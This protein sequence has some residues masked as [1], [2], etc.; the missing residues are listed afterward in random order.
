MKIAVTERKS[1]HQT[2]TLGSGHD[3]MP[4]EPE[5]SHSFIAIVQTYKQTNSTYVVLI[6]LILTTR[7]QGKKT[8]TVD[9]PTFII[10]SSC[11]EVGLSSFSFPFLFLVFH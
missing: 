4:S 11:F 10:L 9:N 8:T 6:W 5:H 1:E 7:E 2:S 3:A